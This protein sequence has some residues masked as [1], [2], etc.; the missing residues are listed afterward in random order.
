VVT[1]QPT[2]Q[3][4]DLSHLH[5]AVRQAALLPADQ[6]LAVIRADRWIGYPRASQALARL[7][8]LLAWPTRQ[9]MPNMLLIGPTNN[10]KSM[11]IEKF[12]RAHPPGH[13]PDREHIPVL[14]LQMP[15]NPSPPRF[16]SAILA[17]LGAPTYTRDRTQTDQREQI[18]LDLLKKVGVRAL[19][20]DELHNL[21]A[22]RSDTRREFLNVLRYLGNQLRIPLVGVGTQEAYL[23]IRSDEQLE[24]RFEPFTLPIWQP[25]D[26]ARSL[27]ASFT[28]SYPLHRPSRLDTSQMAEY[29]LARSE[30]TIGELAA[31]L[32][33]AADA[34]ITSG[35]EQITDT[36]LAMA[37]YRGPTE[38]RHLSARHL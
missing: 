18:A 36:T 22:G 37:D 27:L 25:D 11:I 20:I 24:N 10:G 13:E 2:T 28:A 15:P 12:R 32:T 29:L 26:A 7:E 23:A 5:P 35:I 8:A 33:A 30:G 31:L 4:L 16:Y 38:R 14:C 6:R 1:E 34:A 3:P 21:L 9:R 19:V 17:A